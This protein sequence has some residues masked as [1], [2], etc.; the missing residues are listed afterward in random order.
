MRAVHGLPLDG[1]VLSA[2]TVVYA[3]ELSAALLITLWNQRR[4]SRRLG[5]VTWRHSGPSLYSAGTCTD[6]EHMKYDAN[7]FL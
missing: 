5:S 1:V 3:A 6:M 7:L 2:W 4:C